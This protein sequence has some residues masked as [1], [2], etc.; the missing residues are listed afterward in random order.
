MVNMGGLLVGRQGEF[1]WERA[2]VEKWAGRV[3][4]G[5][6]KAGGGSRSLKPLGARNQELIQ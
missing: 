2:Q 4:L 1:H 6:T 5:S 3:S